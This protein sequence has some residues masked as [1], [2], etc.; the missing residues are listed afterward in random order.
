MSESVEKDKYA[1]N[2]VQCVSFYNIANENKDSE[3]KHSTENYIKSDDKFYPQEVLQKSVNGIS[4][5]TVKIEGEVK[6]ELIN[7]QSVEIK[8]QEEIEINSEPIHRE[9]LLQNSKCDLIKHKRTQTGNNPYKCKQCSKAL[10]TKSGFI[11]HQR[12]DTGEKPYKCG[13]CDKAY[14]QNNTLIIH[15]RTHTGERPY[16]CSQCDKAFSQNSD[17]IKHLRTHTG[18]KPYQCSQCDKSFSL[19]TNL[20]T[21]QR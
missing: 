20:I 14:S 9:K 5:V 8:L 16:Q 18:E 15:M 3:M 11:I 6:E 21:H 7:I 4:E 17:L 1:N 13:Q 2:F 10:S 19:K 12:M